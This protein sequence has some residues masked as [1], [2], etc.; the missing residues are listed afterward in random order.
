MG[1]CVQL[2]LV[3][4]WLACAKEPRTELPELDG[5]IAAPGTPRAALAIDRDQAAVAATRRSAR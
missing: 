3:L 1:R 2:I 5:V 4:S